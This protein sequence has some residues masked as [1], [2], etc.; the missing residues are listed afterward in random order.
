MA[1]QSQ[2]VAGT[3]PVLSALLAGHA[4]NF[5]FENGG[6]KDDPDIFNA[7]SNIIIDK[8]VFRGHKDIVRGIALSNDGNW[9]YSGG[10]DGKLLVWSL[11]DPHEKPGILNTNGLTKNGIR[12]VALAEK[13][14]LA[15]TTDG[16]LLIWNNGEKGVT[17]QSITAH[18]GIINK[19]GVISPNRVITAGADGYFKI[20]DLNATN[21][22]L[23]S[24]QMD[25]PVKDIA[26]SGDGNKLALANQNGIVK[27]YQVS[28]FKDA[29]IVLN[30]KKTILS[31]ALNND[32]GRLISGDN[33]GMINLWN[34]TG[35]NKNPLE[36][37]ADRSGITALR[38]SPDNKA[39][40]SASY[41]N[42]IRIWNPDEPKQNP[43]MISGHDSWVM[44]VT[45]T[46]DGNHLITAG[47]DK[48]IRAFEINSDLLSS[49][50]CSRVNR[51]LTKNEW[52]TFVGKD[53]KYQELCPQIKTVK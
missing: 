52:I 2:R 1:I 13:T 15:G 43:I 29:P 46:S 28:N 47:N 48:T 45:F 12:C 18:S 30:T 6:R 24:G 14:V 32:G 26:I 42:T 8:A 5:N 35:Q 11:N 34:L 3:N 21:Q 22:P 20:W 19:I 31:V 53:I 44:D 49:R 25:A 23:F 10:D 17:P 16:I 9:I 27:I 40:V 37:L 7:L 33:S 36:Y 41:D 50:I 4:Y 38:F 51:N 39:F